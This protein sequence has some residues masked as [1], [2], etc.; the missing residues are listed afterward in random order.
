[1]NRTRDLPVCSTVPQPTAPPRAPLALCT[2]PNTQQHIYQEEHRMHGFSM[3]CQPVPLSH[4][5]R[6]QSDL[7]SLLT[8]FSQ[9]Q[10][11]TLQTCAAADITKLTRGNGTTR[12]LGTH[13]SGKTVAPVVSQSCHPFTKETL[14]QVQFHC[15]ASTFR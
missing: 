2:T 14:K 3:C 11:Q 4:N 9:F 15:H 1:M 10:N 8:N 7:L 13:K 6:T 12:N 5:T